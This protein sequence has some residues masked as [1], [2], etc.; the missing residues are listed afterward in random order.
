MRCKETIG[1]LRKYL[2]QHRGGQSKDYD[3]VCAYPK[4]TFTDNSATMDACGLV[5]NGVLWLQ[6][7]KKG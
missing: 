5:P 3:V 6:A 4:K 1:D 7:K 2:D